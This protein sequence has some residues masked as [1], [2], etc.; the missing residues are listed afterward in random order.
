MSPCLK[1]KKKHSPHPLQNHKRG[2][3]TPYWSG[4]LG[5]LAS[6]SQAST[7]QCLPST[8]ITGI[9]HPSPTNPA[10][11][12]FECRPWGLNSGSCSCKASTLP[13]E[14]S[15]RLLLPLFET[16]SHTYKLASNDCV[17]KDHLE[18]TI[19]PLPPPESWDYN[20]RSIHF[21]LC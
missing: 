13:T 3:A 9:C 10:P 19:F 6:K 21:M 11:S 16:G 20:L 17:A 1:Q 2:G 12:L 4:T 5:C 8:K 14:T 15:S 18:L 7:C